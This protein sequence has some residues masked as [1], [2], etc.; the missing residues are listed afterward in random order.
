M[1]LIALTAALSAIALAACQT[2]EDEFTAGRLETPC[3]GTLPICAVRAGCVLD[4]GNFVRGAFP[5]AVRVVVRAE[6]DRA[7]LRL[8]LLLDDQLYP[9]TEL[10]IQAHGIGCGAVEQIREVDIDL[11]ARAG[12]DQTLEY[13]LP[14]PGRGDHLLE[15]FSDMSARW[16]LAVDVLDAPDP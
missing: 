4:Y 15:L 2:P 10:L 7:I 8:R 1:R 5:G 9:G 3:D 12:E 13:T 11:F 16:V 6:R 14:L